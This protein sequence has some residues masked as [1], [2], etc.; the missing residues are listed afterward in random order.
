[1]KSD[2]LTECF[3]Q[4]HFME[5][6][7]K[8]ARKL[9]SMPAFCCKDGQIQYVITVRIWRWIT[10]ISWKIECCAQCF[11]TQDQKEGMKAFSGKKENRILSENSLKA[12]IPSYSLAGGEYTKLIK[13][14]LV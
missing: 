7:K 3:P 6:T 13:G 1:M 4:H 2:W 9:A 8:F 11:S 14:G 10:P 12:E 5:E